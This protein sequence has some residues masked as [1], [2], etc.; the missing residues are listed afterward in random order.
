[1]TNTIYL[2]HFISTDTP[3]YGG[4][5]G[6]KIIPA[7]SMQHG[8][9]CNTQS[10]TFPNHTGTHIDF[11][12]HFSN[13]GKN[14][15]D[16]SPAQWIFSFPFILDYESKPAEIINIGSAINL[17][18]VQTDFLIIR[19]GFQKFR[20]APEYWQQNPGISP[21]MAIK[22]R[23][24]CKNLRVIGFDF[25]S[26]SSYQHRETGRTAH[27]EF[28]I[29]ND[30]LVVEDMDLSIPIKRINKIICLPLLVEN[31]DGVPVTIIAEI[32]N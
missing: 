31:A 14:L 22:L 30:I 10:L 18:P 19:T 9:S 15:N 29:K 16:Y 27:V 1:M 26:L 21:A 7:K 13:S 23:Q 8:D 2:S 4:A 3:L 32:D 6:I 25:I 5:D 28:L 12:L 17:I 11:P 24:H 20:G